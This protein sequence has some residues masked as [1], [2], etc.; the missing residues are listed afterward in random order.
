[1]EENYVNTIAFIILCLGVLAIWRK[2][3]IARKSY[4]TIRY[5]AQSKPNQAPWRWRIPRK[6]LELNLEDG[7][8]YSSIQFPYNITD[9]EKFIVV[10]GYMFLAVLIVMTLNGLVESGGE[11]A[12]LLFIL[13]LFLLP[14]ACLMVSSR[15]IA[16]TLKPQTVELHMRYGISLHRSYIFKKT[17]LTHCKGRYQTPFS[18]NIDQHDPDYFIYFYYKRLKLF[19]FSRRFNSSCN[20]TQGSW[21]VEGIN[22]WISN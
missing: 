14:Y 22:T 12:L 5:S 11:L 2:Y 1:M 16:I 3:Y 15:L 8:N 6:E 18:M 20:Q 17:Q 13:P 10:F 7:E 19:P 21:I 4:Y 9:Y